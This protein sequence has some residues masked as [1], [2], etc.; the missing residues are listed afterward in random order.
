MFGMCE[1][2]ME[3]KYYIC[4]DLKSFYASVECVDR[5]LD[6]MTAKLVVADPERGKG[7]ICLAVSPALKA[8]GVRNRCRVF[9]IPDN[10][11]YIMAIPRMQRYIDCS[12]DIYGI[13]LEYFS[14][15]DI[16]VYS[17]DESFIDITPY[18]SLYHKTPHEMAFMLISEVK[19]RL[20][21]IATA[22]VGT[23]LYLAKVALDIISKH[24]PDRIGILDSG[25][26]KRL[27]W[28]HRPLTDF[29]QLGP[30]TARTLNSMGILDM[31]DI[32]SHPDLIRKKFGINSEYMIDHAN[33]IENV[34]IKDIKNYNSRSHSLTSG[35]VLPRNY[36]YE[37]ARLAISEMANELTQTLVARKLLSCGY[38]VYI[39][40]AGMENGISSSKM[41]SE[42]TDSSRRLNSLILD[43]FDTLADP[44][45]EIRRLSIG[46]SPVVLRS[47]RQYSFFNNETDADKDLKVSESINTIRDRYGKNSIVRGM[48]LLDAATTMERNDQ[49]GGHRK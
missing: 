26:Y 22:G 46:Y 40:Y 35:Q 49:I 42:G 17:I 13:Y 48:D 23:N 34:T 4:I 36:K 2:L 32:A 6:P 8:L 10:V 9:E 28:H 27:L 33:G 7:T 37:E 14:K 38:Y 5:G 31:A 15:D 41:L 30:G 44:R 20:S 24:V 12:A 45:Y 11:Q 43:M 1:A 47:S 3:G 18:L 16:H 25:S 29:W 39:G 21:L 19:D